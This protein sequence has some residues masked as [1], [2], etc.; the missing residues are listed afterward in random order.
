MEFL[1]EIIEKSD[2][3][4]TDKNKP[5][6]SSSSSSNSIIFPNLSI[7]C[8]KDVKYKRKNSSSYVNARLN[9]FERTLRTVQKRKIIIALFLL[10]QSVT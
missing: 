1:P 6:R 5:K 4:E 2:S 8:N 3:L 10:Y 9:K 7:F